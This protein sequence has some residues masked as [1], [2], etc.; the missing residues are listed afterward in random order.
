LSGNVYFRIYY[1][2]STIP[3]TRKEMETDSI[4]V[5]D[6]ATGRKEL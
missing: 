6:D 5:K 1:R 4:S 2:E 3:G